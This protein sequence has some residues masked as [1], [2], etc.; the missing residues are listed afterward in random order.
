MIE[1]DERYSTYVFVSIWK[2]SVF[3]ASFVGFTF[4]TGAVTDTANLFNYFRKSFESN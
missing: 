2:M 1:E 3:F 4:Y